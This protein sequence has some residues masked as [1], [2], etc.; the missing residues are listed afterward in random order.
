MKMLRKVG[1]SRVLVVLRREAHQNDRPGPY[2]SKTTKSRR[3]FAN[4]AISGRKCESSIIGRISAGDRFG[5]LKHF[6]KVPEGPFYRFRGKNGK[7]YPSYFFLRGRSRIF[8]DFGPL[9]GH[10]W[11]IFCD[12]SSLGSLFEPCRS[13]I[14]VISE[15][16]LLSVAIPPR[17]LGSS[18]STFFLIFHFVRP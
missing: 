1:K 18:C 9:S 2:F 7:V 14:V 5:V 12:Y 6:L 13:S 10:F 8:H 3:Y 4:P 16:N 15:K 11:S 17:I